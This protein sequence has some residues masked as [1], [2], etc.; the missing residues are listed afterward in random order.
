MDLNSCYIILKKVT[1]LS[2]KCRFFTERVEIL[3]IVTIG[4]VRE[5]SSMTIL[6]VYAHFNKFGLYNFFI[7]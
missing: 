6:M 2:I 5:V 4:N 7:E 3:A 1:L